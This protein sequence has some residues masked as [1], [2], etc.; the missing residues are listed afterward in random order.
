[1]SQK[2]CLVSLNYMSKTCLRK[3]VLFHW[4]TWARLVSEKLSC[5]VELH[6][7]VLSQKSCLVPLN[8]MSKSCLRKVVFFRWITWASLVSE[9]LS[10]S[11]EIHKQVLSQK[12]CYVPLNYMNKSCLRKG[13]LAWIQTVL[14]YLS[15][16]FRLRCNFW[17]I[18]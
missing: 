16:Q 3:V 2:S 17:R 11:V 10:C 4:T 12:T 9:K 18:L 6:E 15:D 7:E 14:V 5:S 13:K 8:Y 1:L